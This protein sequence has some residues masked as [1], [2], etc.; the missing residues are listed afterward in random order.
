MAY[1]PDAMP[2]GHVQKAEKPIYLFVGG[3]ENQTTTDNYDYY[4]Q[5]IRA[6]SKNLS[7][8]TNPEKD[9]LGMRDGLGDSENPTRER[10]LGFVELYSKNY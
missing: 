10:I 5:L 4:N 3:Y 2:L 7:I 1:R 8:Y 9:H 6:D